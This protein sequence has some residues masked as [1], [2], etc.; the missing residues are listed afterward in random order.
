MTE[1]ELLALMAACV[2]GHV[3]M[4]DGPLTTTELAIA[5]ARDLLDEIDRAIEKEG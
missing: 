2:W 5:V 3:S 1:R 4:R